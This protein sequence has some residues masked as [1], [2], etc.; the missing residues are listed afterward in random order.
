MGHCPE[1]VIWKIAERIK[2]K[3]TPQEYKEFREYPYLCGT[4]VQASPHPVK[5]LD[6]IRSRRSAKPGEKISI[7]LLEYEFGKGTAAAY[8]LVIVDNSTRFTWLYELSHKNQIHE[9]LER[10]Y[11]K[12]KTQLN[13][14]TY[15]GI[16]SE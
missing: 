16:Y 1:S 4:V 2:R 14:R 6:A 7:D 5:K 8:G 12:F 9:A 15:F 10:V 11:E 13:A 3:F